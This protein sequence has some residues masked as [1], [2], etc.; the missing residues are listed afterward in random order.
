MLV[1]IDHLMPFERG[2][3]EHEVLEAGHLHMQQFKLEA[4]EDCFVKGHF[5]LGETKAGYH[6]YDQVLSEQTLR[7]APLQNLL[8]PDQEINITSYEFTS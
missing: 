8:D 7:K 6:L 3:A 4:R 2:N 5:N 1:V